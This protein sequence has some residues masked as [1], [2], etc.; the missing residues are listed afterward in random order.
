HDWFW[1]QH[2]DFPMRPRRFA[3]ASCLR[4]HH[5]VTDLAPSPKFP[6]PPAPKLLAGYDLVRQSGCFG[7]H[8]IRGVTAL[9]EKVGPDM[10]L[11]PNDRNAAKDPLAGTMSK[12]GPSLRNVAGKLDAVFL[13]DWLRNPRDSRPDTR[14]PQFYGVHEHLAGKSLADARRFEAVEIY[15]STEYLLASSDPVEPLKP[16][17]EVTE[18]PSAERGKQLFLTQGCLAC[19]RHDD[20]P[21]AASI[22][23]PNLSNLASKLNHE[24]GRKW[25]EGWIRD[26]AHHS[27]KTLMPNT[28]L[29]PVPLVDEGDEGRG[30]R[31]Q[32]RG[33]RGEGRGTEG[34][35]VG[36][37]MTDPAADI[38][39]YLLESPEPDNRPSPGGTGVSPVRGEHGQDA[40]ATRPLV[41]SDLDD[42]V[43]LH[44]AP[45]IS[46][47][48]ARAHLK[49]EVEL[50]VEQAQDDAVEL[51]GPVTLEKKVRYVGRRTIAKRG[52]FGCHDIPGFEDAQ[53]IGPALSDWGRKQQ[54]LLAFGQIHQ[55][56]ARSSAAS[57]NQASAAEATAAGDPGGEGRGTRDEKSQ[58]RPSPLIPHPSPLAPHPSPLTDD[59]YTEALLAHR[60]EG[61]LWQ[62]LRAPRSFDYK[63]TE[64][65]GYNERLTMGRFSFTPDEREAIITFVLGLVSD[66]PAADYVYQGDRRRQAIAE[67]RKVLDKYACA[68]CHTLEMGRWRV[69]YD[70]EEIEAPYEVEDFA[71]LGPR[72]DAESLETSSK[73]DRRGLLH[74]E[75]V[76]MAE[77][78]ESGEVLEDVD[79]DDHPMVYV[80]LWEPLSLKV[81]EEW[82]AWPAGGQL[83]ISDPLEVTTGAPAGT[84]LGATG[85]SPVPGEHGQDARATRQRTVE[86]QNM[87]PTYTPHLAGTRP[88][89]GGAFARLL[90]PHVLD[91]D[92]PAVM[93]AWG[94]VPPPLV[95]EGFKVQPEWLYDYLLE[96]FAIRPAVVLRMPKYNLSPEEAG[97]LVDYFAAVAGVDFPYSF[98]PRGQI[99]DL[100]AKELARP[101]R[102]DDAMR[103]VIDRTTY[104]TKC[105]LVGDYSPGGETQTVLAPRLDR[106]GPRLRPEYLH[107]WLANPKTLL[108]YTGMPVNFP[109]AG[110]P[111]GQELFEG[112]SLEQLD[113]VTD[114]LLNYHGH[115]NGRSSIRAVIESAEK[116][117]AKTGPGEE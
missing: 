93:A 108:P 103:I 89:V 39:A 35:A 43:L 102:L 80:N 112:S 34:E 117:P 114:L 94:W 16:P 81:E 105:H 25:L 37:R 55:F 77:R 18:A 115:M 85:V 109:P 45:V 104:C 26:P 36:P 44:L 110:P 9:G 47:R 46:T 116:A 113:A 82:M 97:K 98:D 12:V 71:F 84:G 32:G 8:E 91:E 59:F 74:A 100:E 49:G 76:G 69:E 24:V 50:T 54:S 99:A 60:R 22:Q 79:D 41:E 2:W 17:P 1:N 88:T 6:D 73:P 52:C 7:C 56:P 51:L 83:G 107:R 72:V 28:L 38:A 62:K 13:D 5:A 90:F 67:G 78:D 48:L 20:F 23:G 68:E 61:F 40:R 65:K 53:P 3:E 31:D 92:N 14:M 27:P 29:E 21:E 101:N 63:T 33:A 95:G 96:P 57:A 4:C 111:M 106:V 15:A 87:R 66:P 70:P 10:R 30:T 64:N 19:H 86:A 58:T 75:A 42:L 11:E